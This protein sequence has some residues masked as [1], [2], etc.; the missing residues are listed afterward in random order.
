MSRVVVVVV[1]VVAAVVAVLALRDTAMTVHTEMP[2][3]SRLEVEASA[4]WRGKTETAPRLA[5]ALAIQCVAETR[6]TALLDAFAWHGGDFTFTVEPALDEADRKQLKG[7]L[8][9]LRMPHL[10]VAVDKMLVV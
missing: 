4:R 10:I 3:D 8:S 1:L 9:D 6:A 5:E 2:A 7:C